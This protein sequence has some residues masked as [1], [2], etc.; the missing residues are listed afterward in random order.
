MLV[1]ICALYPVD[2]VRA[3]RAEISRIHL[4]DIEAAVRHLWM[5]GFARCARILI[6]AGMTGDATQAFV[7][8][9]RGAIVS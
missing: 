3:G 7:H 4:L 8:T 2:V 6:V 9:N 1:A 5:A